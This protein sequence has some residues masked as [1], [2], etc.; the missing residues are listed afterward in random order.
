ML[1]LKERYQLSASFLLAA[2]KDTYSVNFSEHYIVIY[3]LSNK[4]EIDRIDKQKYDFIMSGNKRIHFLYG[5]LKR[6]D[7]NYICEYAGI[8]NSGY[9]AKNTKL[10]QEIIG[11]NIE[12]Q[13]VILMDNSNII[14]L[15]IE[16]NE[17]IYWIRICNNFSKLIDLPNDTLS[18]AANGIPLTLTDL[19]NINEYK[20][21]CNHKEI[22][23]KYSGNFAVGVNTEN[24]YIFDRNNLIKVIKSENFISDF[25]VIDA[26]LYI[27]EVKDAISKLN[28]YDL[29]EN[30]KEEVISDLGR[31]ELCFP[32]KIGYTAKVV[33]LLQGVTFYNCS[34]N[35]KEV[36]KQ[37]VYSDLEIN[38]DKTLFDSK[39]MY[40]YILSNTQRKGKFNGNIFSFHGG[41]ESYEQLDDRW[42]GEYLRYIS[43][44]YRIF[45]VNYPGSVSFG[46]AYKVLPW[47]NWSKI[48]NTGIKNL[49]R[50]SINLKKLAT[51]T[52]WCWGGSFGAPIAFKLAKYL[53]D[54]NICS[55]VNLLLI[56]PLIDLNEHIN[57]LK[58]EDKKWFQKRF[59]LKDILYLSINKEESIP[60]FNIYCYKGA[61]DEILTF[62]STVDYFS[63][64]TKRGYKNAKL[65][66]DS[67][68]KHAPQNFKEEVSLL[69][70]IEKAMKGN[71]C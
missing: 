55:S 10:P 66:I 36:L 53:T 9:F 6:T 22:T 71:T 12:L 34:F 1:S 11:D 4:T 42:L 17:K 15:K 45:I 7:N 14:F 33:N 16:N 59:S 29:K 13:D 64:L 52:T 26:Q 27:V 37:V 46:K 43:L 58:E 62:Q 50:D 41:P 19:N 60:R 44:G 49:I 23:Y 30:K 70:F 51:N 38:V 25:E 65:V 18:I 24:I 63:L 48:F 69:D 47:K 61:K 2:S 20:K 32:S 39:H 56:S 3:Q 40:T 31:I 28:I 57:K 21:L 68:M 8:S 54:K 67:T 35:H 5:R